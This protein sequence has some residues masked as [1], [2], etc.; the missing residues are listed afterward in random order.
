VTDQ[1]KTV[2]SGVQPTGAMHYG[3]YLGAFRNWVTLQDDDAYNVIYC[4]VDLHAITVPYDPA[5]MQERIA[6]TAKVCCFLYLFC[7]LS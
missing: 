3:G 4:I 7:F 5:E 2:F 6:S 1:K